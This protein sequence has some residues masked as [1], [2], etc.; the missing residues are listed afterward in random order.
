MEDYMPAVNAVMVEKVEEDGKEEDKEGEWRRA[1][2]L[3]IWHLSRCLHHGQP[4]LWRP[5]LGIVPKRQGD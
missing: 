4:C 1:P 5:S 3:K 2:P